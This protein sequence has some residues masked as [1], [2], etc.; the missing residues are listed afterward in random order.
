MESPW[1]QDNFY[2]CLKQGRALT[3]WISLD[4]S[5]YSNGGIRYFS[6]SHM[7]GTLDHVE[8]N[9]PGSSQCLDGQALEVVS[10]QFDMVVPSVKRGQ[11]LVH[12]SNIVH[13]SDVNISTRH[14]RAITVQLKAVSDNYDSNRLSKYNESV[15]RQVLS[16]A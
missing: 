9:A 7:L 3:I 5:D 15:A 8:S 1:H 10:S 6:G 12:H 13:G 14:R 16:R 11:A 4:G 2:W